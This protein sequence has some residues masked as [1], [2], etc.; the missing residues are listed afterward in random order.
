MLSPFLNIVLNVLVRAT[1]KNEKETKSIAFRGK[2]KEEAKLFL[3]VGDVCTRNK[4]QGQSYFSQCY[5]SPNHI[6]I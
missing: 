2:K 6:T 5:Q 3:F 4:D 1:K